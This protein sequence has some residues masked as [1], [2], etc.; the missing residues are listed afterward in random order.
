MSFLKLILKNPFRKRSNAILSIVGISIGIAAI[1]TLGLLTG[2]MSS[3]LEGTIHNEGSDFT[4]CGNDVGS[5]AYGTSSIDL[6]WKN[7]IANMTGVKNVFE[8]YVVNDM[9][10]GSY[11]TLIGLNPNGTSSAD[12]SITQGRLY[13]DNA[14][15]IVLG[16]LAA[17]SD[18]ISVGDS[19]TLFGKTF[20]VVGIYES[21]K[22]ENDGSAYTSIGTIQKLMDDP[23]KIS[24]IYVKVAD[25]YD[26]Q[27]VADD[28]NN[29]YGD[30]VTAVTSVREMGQMGDML[31]MVDSASL[32]ISI[33]AIVIGGIGI[34]NTMLMSVLDRTRELGVLKAVGWSNK[35]VLTMIMGESLTLTVISGIVGSIIGVILMNIMGPMM[36]FEIMYSPDVFIKAFVVA[37]VVGLIGGLYPAIKAVKLPPT[38]SLRYE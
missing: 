35:K 9:S 31:N 2:S 37:I 8:I 15:E 38:E 29:K 23:N 18:N 28:I 1:V 6:S 5:S 14:D 10:G 16:K 13:H 27:T 19:K 26:P 4:V 33:L 34:I 22:Q 21:G 11:M 36:G 3:A 7:K 12:L 25:G 32:A 24:N 20:K 17:D 30:N